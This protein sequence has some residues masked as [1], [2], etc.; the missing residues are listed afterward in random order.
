MSVDRE[1]LKYEHAW[2]GQVREVDIIT[3]FEEM[4]S[5]LLDRRCRNYGIKEWP[6]RIIYMRDG[7]GDSTLSAM[8]A[9]EVMEMNEIYK[10]R[11]LAPPRIL[12]M[13]VRK[14]HQTRFFPKTQDSRANA[15]PGTLI[16]DSL[17]M[18][19]T[20]PNFYLLSHAGI[21]GTSHPCRYIVVRDDFRETDSRM[22]GLNKKELLQY[23]AHL[24]YQLCHTYGRCQRTVSI[25]A[26]VYYAHLCADRAR[27]HVDQMT[28]KTFGLGALSEDSSVVSATALPQPT[29]LDDQVLDKFIDGMNKKLREVEAGAVP[30]CYA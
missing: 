22:K 24:C 21:K 9:S 4:L 8:I 28:R 15:P 5:S 3:T 23:Y 7:V 12:A 16:I 18:P 14:R 20:L 6:S 2:R 27:I 17:T 13:A 11:G 26:P 1:G 19:L 29:R 30:M 10:R 25:P